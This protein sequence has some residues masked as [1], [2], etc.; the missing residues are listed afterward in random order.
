MIRDIHPGSGFFPSRIPTIFRG[1]KD[2][3]KHRTSDPESGSTTLAG[4]FFEITIIIL[5][6]TLKVRVLT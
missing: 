3:K 6:Q 4:T 1:Q 2:A 5:E